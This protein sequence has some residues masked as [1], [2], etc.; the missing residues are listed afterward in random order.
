MQS[1]RNNVSGILH[2]LHHK[3]NNVSATLH[4][5]QCIRNNVSGV[6]HLCNLSETMFPVFY[7]ACIPGNIVSGSF[8]P[9]QLNVRQKESSSVLSRKMTRCWCV[10]RSK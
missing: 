3:R 2:P 8:E 7:I 1:L 6:F 4:L 9:H 10:F 5:L